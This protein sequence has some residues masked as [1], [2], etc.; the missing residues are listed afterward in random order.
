MSQ[1]DDRGHR[2]K[3]DPLQEAFKAIFKHAKHPERWETEQDSR[4]FIRDRMKS[5]MQEHGISPDDLAK[6]TKLPIETIRAFLDAKADLN[7]SAPITAIEMALK[8]NL[9]GW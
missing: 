2:P 7:D 1:F 8:V 3:K 5:A 9:P 6:T 4:L